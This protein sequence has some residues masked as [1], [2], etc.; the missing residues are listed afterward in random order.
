M[1]KTAQQ[2]C[3]HIPLVFLI[4]RDAKTSHLWEG[5]NDALCFLANFARHLAR[6]A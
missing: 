5:L 4:G 6:L 1:S 3:P 2:L